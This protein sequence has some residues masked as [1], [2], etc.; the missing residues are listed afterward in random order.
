M[1]PETEDLYLQNWQASVPAEYKPRPSGLNR[2]PNR[3]ALIN[4]E[5]SRLLSNQFKA[6]CEELA[7]MLKPKKEPPKPPAK[8]V[9]RS[10]AFKK[11]RHEAIAALRLANPA[12]G[13][14]DLAKAL[15]VSQTTILRDI[16]G[17]R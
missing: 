3:S 11:E 12:I 14:P 8:K 17:S 5:P 9:R 13:V 6:S 4:E 15:G 1:S 7:K 2:Y 16:R 10:K